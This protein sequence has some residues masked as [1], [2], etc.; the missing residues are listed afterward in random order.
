M[1]QERERLASRI[2]FIFLSA[3]CAIG[4][5]NVWRFPFITGQHGGGAFVLIYILFLLIFGLPIMVME[6]SIGRASQ[7]NIGLALKTLQPK[8][9]KWHVYGPIAIAGNYVLMMFYTVVS[10]W[11]FS[12]F[13]KMT[14]GKLSNLNPDQVAS[15]F[16]G[17]LQNPLSMT[18]WMVV[19]TL[20]GLGIVGI[21]LQKGVEK[22]TMYMMSA[23]F[24]V[25]FLLVIKSLSLPGSGAGLKFYLLP[26]F[27][28][29]VESGLWKTIYA[30]M[31]QSFFTLS[32]GIGSMAIFGSYIGK[33]RSLTGE[34]INIVA[35]DLSL[36][37]FKE[38]FDLN[39]YGTVIPTQ[40]FS[41]PM[42]E[43][44]YGSIINFASVS[45][46]NPLTKV[47]A[48][49]SAKAAVVNFTKWLATHYAKTNVR[50]NA[51][52]P[53]FLM[54]EQ[55]KFLHLDK[56]G[57]YTTRAKSVINHT[58]M[59]RYGEPNELVGSIVYLVSKASKFVT[60][61]LI[62]LDGGFSAYTI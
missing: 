8:G 14:T 1:S 23:L 57:N 41:K 50:V 37:G 40:I 62:T 33:D 59:G 42:V 28:R 60:G 34:S 3:G 43:A 12:Y 25:M 48:Y 45:S 9:T 17:M 26:D 39:Y 21:G 47:V 35:L 18:F 58:P 11:L 29:L 20:L 13:W 16:G 31:G 4:L 51:I 46:I 38:T 55:L 52:A 6:F 15:Q 30:A 53:G 36:E 56:E 32:L 24:A 7:Q 10:G 44:S 2:G 49:S 22:I 54:T 19:A 5:G 27:S 61:S